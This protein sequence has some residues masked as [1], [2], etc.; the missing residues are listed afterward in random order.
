VLAAWGGGVLLLS[1]RLAVGVVWLIALSRQLQPVPE[2]LQRRFDRLVKRMG[3]RRSPRLVLSDRVVEPFAWQW[4]RPLVVLPASWITDV[5]AE[6]L[7]AVVAHELAHIRRHDLWVNLLQRFVETILFFHPCVWWVSRQIR[8]ERELCCDAEAVAATGQAVAY[9]RALETVAIRRMAC[10]GPQLGVA[11]GGTRMALLHRVKRVLGTETSAAESGWWSLGLAGMGVTAACWTAMTFTTPTVQGDESPAGVV[12]VD[13]ASDFEGEFAQREDGPPKPG[14]RDG[15]RPD[16]PRG[17]RE[18]DR[19]DAP[20]GP[21]DG[22]RPPGAGP[23]DGD[24][25]DAPRG[26]RGGERGEGPRR[27]GDGERGPGPDGRPGPRPE[28]RDGPPR[29]D[30][31]PPMEAM[32]DMM[33]AI[34]ELRE[35]VQM[36]RRELNEIREH[37]PGPREGQRGP[38]LEGRPGPRDGQRGPGP[39]GRPVPRPEGRE[40]DHG[41]GPEAR[42]G[43]RGPRPEGRG[44]MPRPEGREGDRG[45][46]PEGREGDRG[47]RPE[48]REG[49]HPRPPEGRDGNRPRPPEGAPRDRRPDAE[50]ADDDKPVSALLGS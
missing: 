35:E 17:P 13:P 20:R 11:M 42:E 48:G 5:P 26:P 40:G 47:P 6:V 39:E 38:G 14:P 44:P 4:L 21:R 9:A 16:A 23:R 49:D 31:T 25:P 18:G 37:G 24:R 29:G 2:A 43:N 3:L 45:P 15:D 10:A 27:P 41:P 12:S 50:R 34:R 1:T 28:F 30:F 7:E 22:E 19:P 33:Q 36:L 46:R 8:A 32:H